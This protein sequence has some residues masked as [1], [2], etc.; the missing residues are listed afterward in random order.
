M[1]LL[2]CH[3]GGTLNLHQTYIKHHTRKLQTENL[4]KGGG[5]LLLIYMPM[6]QWWSVFVRGRGKVEEQ[7]GGGVE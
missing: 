3:V 6:K 7:G 5:E 4:V 1:V 2:K